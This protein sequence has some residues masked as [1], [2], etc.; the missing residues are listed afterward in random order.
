MRQITIFQN[1]EMKSAPLVV[2]CDDKD[3]IIHHDGMIQAYASGYA[4]AGTFMDAVGLSWFLMYTD[5]SEQ[6]TFKGDPEIIAYFS[7]E[8]SYLPIVVCRTQLDI[9]GF[10]QVMEM[11]Q[12]ESDF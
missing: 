7:P 5:E 9:L 8:V 4:P 6:L 1:Q 3:P 11:T 10:M 2:L 12:S